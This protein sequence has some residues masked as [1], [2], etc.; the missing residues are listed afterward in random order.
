[1]L[2]QV[3][4]FLL[5]VA[6]AAWI[7]MLTGNRWLGLL[8]L[9]LGGPMLGTAS[10]LIQWGRYTLLIGMYMMFGTLIDRSISGER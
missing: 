4:G 5:Y 1:M 6:L 2:G 7:T 10:L 8:T 9:L 3:L